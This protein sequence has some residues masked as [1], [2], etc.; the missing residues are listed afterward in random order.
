MSQ[1]LAGRIQTVLSDELR[2]S[3]SLETLA[4][5]NNLPAEK[6]NFNLVSVDF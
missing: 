3:H 5:N 6:Y 4:E 2:E 1:Q